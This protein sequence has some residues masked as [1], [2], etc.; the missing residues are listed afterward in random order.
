MTRVIHGGSPPGAPVYSQQ[1]LK[2]N[3]TVSQLKIENH[4]SVTLLNRLRI[5][6]RATTSRERKGIFNGLRDALKGL[7][8]VDSKGP[9]Q[10]IYE[11]ID[12]AGNHWFMVDTGGVPSHPLD[13][14]L[15][16]D[17]FAIQRSLN[18][19]HQV[20]GKVTGE[21]PPL[22]SKA[23]IEIAI[24]KLINGATPIAATQSNSNVERVKSEKANE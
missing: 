9:V 17:Y 20:I 2:E 21:V 7:G 23:I 14:G 22:E 13:Q 8:L 3:H 5:A 6:T 18:D 24:K 11:G 10:G 16:D 12:S 15:R 1:H 19:L 4:N